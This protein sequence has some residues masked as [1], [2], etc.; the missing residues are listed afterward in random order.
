[1]KL[2]PVLLGSFVLAVAGIQAGDAQ[3][4]AATPKYLFDAVSQY[5]LTASLLTITGVQHGA[6]A[7]STVSVPLYIPSNGAPQN[8]QGTTCERQLLVAVNRPGRFSVGVYLNA[9][10][11]L[12]G[13]VLTQLP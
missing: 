10:A 3:A 9:S 13:C 4:Q 8:A 11:D 12:N 1:M 7:A 2:R 5:A 6:S